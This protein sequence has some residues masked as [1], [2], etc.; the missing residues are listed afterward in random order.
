MWLVAQQSKQVCCEVCCAHCASV[1]PLSP[2]L[3]DP[4]LLPELDPLLLP[5]LDPL[6]L[7]ELLPLL[8]LLP[9]SEWDPLLLPLLLVVPPS[10]KLVL[11][12]LEQPLAYMA[13]GRATAPKMDITRIT[14]TASSRGVQ[15][16]R[17]AAAR[18]GALPA[19]LRDSQCDDASN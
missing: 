5:E 13:R 3:L 2:P 17:D 1:E 8:E 7:P 4:L 14:F 19:A 9:P 6:L 15:R 18:C 16:P 12:L 10:P 11:A